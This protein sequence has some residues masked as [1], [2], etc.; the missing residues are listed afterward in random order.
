MR[1]TSVRLVVSA[2]LAGRA[3]H[4]AVELDEACDAV[5]T[6]YLEGLRGAGG[7]PF[8]VVNSTPGCGT[9]PRFCAIR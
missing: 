2:K 1:A 7:R 3:E 8:V 9:L 6:G 5:L 4:L